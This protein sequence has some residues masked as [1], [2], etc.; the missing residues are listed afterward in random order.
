MASTPAGKPKG[1]WTIQE[2]AREERATHMR[3]MRDR[4]RGV[5]VNL[6]EASAFARAA[7]TF[8]QAF[9]HDRRA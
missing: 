4:E 9:V 7:N 1:P 2:I 8:A 5:T 6:E 3:V